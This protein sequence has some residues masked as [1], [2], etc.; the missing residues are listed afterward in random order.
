MRTGFELNSVNPEKRNS[1]YEFEARY[2][3]EYTDAR[4]KNARTKSEV[5]TE[6]KV[7]VAMRYPAEI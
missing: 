3:T 1:I 5:I 2:F 4:K 7:T 6:L